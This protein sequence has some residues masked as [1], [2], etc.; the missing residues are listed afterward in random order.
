MNI[1]EAIRAAGGKHYP[2]NSMQVQFETEAQFLAA[3][4]L[5]RPMAGEGASESTPFEFFK[6]AA[7]SVG[8]SVEQEHTGGLFKERRTQYAWNALAT[9]KCWNPAC[10]ALAATPQAVQQEVP[11]RCFHCE[12]SFTDKDAARLHFGTSEHHQPACQIDVAEYRAMEA[13]MRAYNEED[14]ELHRDIHRLESKHAVERRSEE[15]KGYAR[16]LRDSKSCPCAASQAQ[17]EQGVAVGWQGRKRAG[18]V[19]Y[20]SWT[21]WVEVFGEELERFRL[22]AVQ[23]PDIFEL[24]ALFTAPQPSPAGAV[25]AVLQQA[26]DAL[27][28]VTTSE[29]FYRDPRGDT[30]GPAIDALDRL[31][32]ATPTA[33]QVDARD[34]L[35]WREFRKGKPLTVSVPTPTDDKPNKRTTVIYG[36]NPEPSY[37]AALDAAI[38]AAISKEQPHG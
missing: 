21:A 16:G 19:A 27:V 24:R 8:L 17:A 7:V 1:T 38:D 6:K 20:Q 26:R 11:W 9:G 32:A 4:A 33:A 14:T 35:R 30:A 18:E 37:P 25:H 31:L 5:V 12:E 23:R 29:T 2:H 3:A 36:P 34:A 15:E 22:M 28:T 13:R 10:A